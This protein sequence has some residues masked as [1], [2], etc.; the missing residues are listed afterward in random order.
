VL[1]EDKPIRM[2][3]ESSN[4][5]YLPAKQA[6]ACALVINELL[7]NAIEHAYVNRES[8]QIAVQL[9]DRGDEVSMVVADDGE[10]L[11]PNFDLA[12]TD[13]LGLSI[14]KTLAEDD[15]KGTF[16]LESERGTTATV[17]FSKKVW[18]GE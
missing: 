10:G 18:E 2:S 5:L 6:T 1:S 7:M 14:V 13:S 17:R 12:E 4:N 15:L 9:E 11:P 3:L 16:V 8:G